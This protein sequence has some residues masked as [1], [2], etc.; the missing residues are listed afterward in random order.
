[1]LLI[2]ISARRP[3]LLDSILAISGRHQPYLNMK[4]LNQAKRDVQWLEWRKAMGSEYKSLIDNR[5]WTLVPPK[6]GRT[7]LSGK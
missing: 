7:V 1:M 5:T 2:Y 4:N 3:S 6:I